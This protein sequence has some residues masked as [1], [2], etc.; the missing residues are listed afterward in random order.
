M[1]IQ[2]QPEKRKRVLRSAA[3]G[4][5]LAGLAILFGMAWFLAVRPPAIDADR[6]WTATV[7][8]SQL[9]REVS[10]AGKLVAPELR[11]VT[12]RSEGVVERIVRLPG[13]RVDSD[14]V[15]LV[16]SS[17]QIEQDL[18]ASR[19][20]LAAAEAEEALR[21]VEASNRLL[22]LVAQVASAKAD[23]TSARLEVEAQEELGEGAVFSAIEVKRTRLHAEQLERRLEAERTRLDRYPEYQ[24]A[25]RDVSHARLSRLREQVKQLESRLKELKVRADTDGVVQE[26]NVEE[27]QR[28][29]IGQSVARVVNP[30]HLIARIHV[31]E[32]DAA[33]ISN[34]MPVKLEVG[35]ERATG[36]VMRIDPTVRDRAV[37][38]DVRLVSQTDLPLRPDLSVT[39]RIELERVDDAL[40]IDRPLAVR[41]ENESI[42]L[43]RLSASGHRAERVPVQIGH[44]SQR[45]VEIRR[46]LQAGDRVILSDLPDLQEKTVVR[47]R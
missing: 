15:L 41:G 43:F 9:V 3:V 36:E 12:N 31:A 46:G 40:V 28:L 34:G 25:Q 37:N 44:T 19:W 33:D 11:A 1:D 21:Q 10:A 18:A 20:E 6:I 30:E 2:L 8:R 32:R 22:D 7:T 29:D 24:S 47:I 23:F 4:A 13:D 35:R 39:A 5:A 38:V 14:D 16:M 42:E 27:G 45:Q 26:I 17:P